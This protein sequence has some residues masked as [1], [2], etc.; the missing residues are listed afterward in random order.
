MV[1]NPS[2]ILRMTFNPIVR[3]V[4]YLRNKNIFFGIGLQEA[5]RIR[6]NGQ[7]R[8]SEGIATASLALD[9]MIRGGNIATQV[10]FQGGLEFNPKTLLCSVR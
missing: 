7:V 4:I 2:E 9:N 10:L 3:G 8:T 5:D 1:E 6:Y